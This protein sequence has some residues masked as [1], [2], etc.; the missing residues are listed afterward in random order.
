MYNNVL[1]FL[2][3]A[4]VNQKTVQSSQLVYNQMFALHFCYIFHVISIVLIKLGLQCQKLH[5]VYVFVELLAI[6]SC[7]SHFYSD[8]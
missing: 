4:K 8:I 3:P 1:F 2:R 6:V 7:P 5:E